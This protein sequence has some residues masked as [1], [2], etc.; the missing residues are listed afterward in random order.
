LEWKFVAFPRSAGRKLAVCGIDDRLQRSPPQ[1]ELTAE[2]AARCK[3]HQ[4]CGTLRWRKCDQSIERPSLRRSGHLV[5]LGIRIGTQIHRLAERAA[6]LTE[7][8]EP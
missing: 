1:V 4:L 5:M 3:S 8:L 2:P 7:H 6:V